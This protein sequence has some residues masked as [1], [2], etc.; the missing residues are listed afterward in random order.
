MLEDD[1][2]AIYVIAVAVWSMFGPIPFIY[3]DEE[4]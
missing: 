3:N 4:D 2:F 1:W